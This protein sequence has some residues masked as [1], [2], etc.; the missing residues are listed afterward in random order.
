MWINI[1]FNE[2]LILVL[3]KSQKDLQ[4]QI[5]SLSKLTTNF[6]EEIENSESLLGELFSKLRKL[7]NDREVE[8]KIELGQMKG[9]GG[10]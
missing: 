2:D 7:I 4:R 1:I 5:V 6:D 9:H 10:I 3:E 8:L